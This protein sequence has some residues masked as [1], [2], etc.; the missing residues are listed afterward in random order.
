[1]SG[2]GGAP[3]HPI[4]RGPDDF[5][6]KSGETFHYC[7]ITVS[8]NRAIFEMIRLDKD[9]GEWIVDDTFTISKK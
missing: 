6:S 3:Q 9:T 8:N 7:K 5:Y 2:G 1:V 4:N